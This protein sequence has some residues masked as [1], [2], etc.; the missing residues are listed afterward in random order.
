MIVEDCVIDMTQVTV[1]QGDDGEQLGNDD[2]TLA[3]PAPINRNMNV[4]R[5][6]TLDDLDGTII[7]ANYADI[8]HKTKLGFAWGLTVHKFQGSEI[9][10]VCYVLTGCGYETSQVIYT[11]VTR[12]RKSV[13]MIG[14]KSQLEK[15]VRTKPKVRQTTLRE[16]IISELKSNPLPVYEDNFD[17]DEYGE[18]SEESD[19]IDDE[20][21]AMLVQ[22]VADVERPEADDS[23]NASFAELLEQAAFEAEYSY[24][25]SNIANDPGANPDLGSDEIDPDFENELVQATIDAE[26]FY[27]QSQAAQAVNNNELE[28]QEQSLVETDLLQSQYDR[29]K[30]RDS[31][32]CATL[33]RNASQDDGQDG[34]SKRFRSNLDF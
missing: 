14:T 7:R 9:D 30:V 25:Q 22:A 12:G 17:I 3:S 11:A 26:F 28:D 2:T 16:R 13:T 34:P 23:I 8:V 31:P 5:F 32:D 24:S 19:D 15:A 29:L 4:D 10:H 1:E 6:L 21:A 18:D 20:F 27:S 33:R